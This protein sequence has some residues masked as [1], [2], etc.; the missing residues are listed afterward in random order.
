MKYIVY[1]AILFYYFTLTT[2]QQ[3]NVRE[4]SFTY[5]ADILNKNQDLFRNWKNNSETFATFHTIL[6]PWLLSDL[7]LPLP[8][9]TT[10]TVI[11]NIDCNNEK[12]SN[13]LTG[14]KLSSPHLMIDLIPFGYDVDKL[15]IRLYELYNYIDL[16]VIYESPYTLIGIPK[17]LYAEK[18][19]HHPR[20]RMFLNKIVYLPSRIEV[21]I[22]IH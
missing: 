18:F 16:F 14:S 13:V 20:F 21:S 8:S 3:N 12:Y 22:H 11:P 4:G 19:L 17:P 15:L 2:Q 7:P 10:A 1:I 5:L 9:N 6:E